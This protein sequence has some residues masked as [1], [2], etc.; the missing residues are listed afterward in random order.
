MCVV[1]SVICFQIFLAVFMRRF[2]IPIFLLLLFSYLLFVFIQRN[3]NSDGWQS[4]KIHKH[5][6]DA[7][8]DM[9]KE[10]ANTWSCS[11]DGWFACSTFCCCCWCSVQGFLSVSSVTMQPITKNIFQV[12]FSQ[13]YCTRWAFFT[14]LITP[15]I[16]I[17]YAVNMDRSRIS[18]SHISCQYADS[19][20]IIVFFVLLL[21]SLPF[22]LSFSWFSFFLL[23]SLSF[24]F[25]FVLF[26]IFLVN[27]CIIRMN[28]YT[29]A[30]CL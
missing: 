11:F 16:C 7:R 29:L 17:V 30:F 23:L 8:A 28:L 26:N 25:Y 22:S 2:A 18:A 19:I 6:R 27:I 24:F 10:F 15:S 14:L 9:Q 5:R 3:Y 12:H 4:K 13:C 20:I 1:L 21:R